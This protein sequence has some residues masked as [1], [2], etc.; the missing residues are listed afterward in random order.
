MDTVLALLQIVVQ[1][2]PGAI[3]TATDLYDLGTRFYATVH[4]NAPTADEQAQLRAQIDADV[5]LAL[6]PLPPA[7]PGDEDY[8]KPAG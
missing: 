8:V 3:K 5:A 4:G 7:Q 6:Q 1:N 2:A